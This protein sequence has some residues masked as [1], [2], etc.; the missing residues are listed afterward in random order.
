MDPIALFHPF[1]SESAGSWTDSPPG[2]RYFSAEMTKMTNQALVCK[3]KDGLVVW[4]FIPIQV[5][6]RSMC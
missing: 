2:L 6:C 1:P 5:Q 4:I 3:Q